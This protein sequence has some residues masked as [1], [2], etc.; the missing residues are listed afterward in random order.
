MRT[1]PKSATREHAQD[2]LL[3]KPD[4]L[5]DIERRIEGLRRDLLCDVDEAGASDATQQHF[6]L[7]LSCLEQAQRFARL[8]LLQARL[9][10]SVREAWPDPPKPEAT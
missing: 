2:Y 7:A 10:E 6:L 8:A 9:A 3:R 4:D 5:R 1:D